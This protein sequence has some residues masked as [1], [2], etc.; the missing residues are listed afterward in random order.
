MSNSLKTPNTLVLLK[1]FC[2]RKTKQFGGLAGLANQFGVEIPANSQADLSSPLLIPELIKSRTFAE[3]ILSKKFYTEK[4]GKELT[5][6]SILTHGVEKPSFKKDTLITKAM[7]PLNEILTFNQDP[8]KAISVLQVKTFEPLF[9][10]D[11]SEIVLQELESLNNQF[12]TK[13][14]SEKNKFYF[15]KDIKC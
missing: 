14:I 4:F 15:F 12:K 6:L 1:Y 5:L 7:K 3:R 9:S 10:K 2:Q 11:L 13:T 8:L